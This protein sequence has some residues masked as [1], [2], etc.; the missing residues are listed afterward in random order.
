MKIDIDIADRLLADAQRLAKDRGM[1]LGE[2]VEQGL[3][4]VLRPSGGVSP[5]FELRRA[6]F[7]GRGLQPGVKALHGSGCSSWLTNGD[8]IARDGSPILMAGDPRHRSP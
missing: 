6:S 4:S 3:R 7:K 1:T 8:P 2:L 5:P